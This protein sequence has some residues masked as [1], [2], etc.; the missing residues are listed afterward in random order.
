MNRYVFHLTSA[1]AAG[2]L[3]LSSC[4]TE[5]QRER[6]ETQAEQ[7]TERAGG[8]MGDAAI[9]TSVK[10]KMA[11]D[12]RLGTLTGVNVDTSSNVV[13]LSGTVPT[14]DD[15]QKAEDA[16]RS[17]EGVTRVVNNLEVRP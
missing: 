12:V 9:T 4:A 6:T 7:M 5:R 10:A 13:T 3:L 8:A 15:K 2:A 14:A 17:V 1:V 11:S 16:A